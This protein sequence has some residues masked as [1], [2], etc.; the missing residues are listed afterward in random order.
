M[1]R[2]LWIVGI[3]CVAAFA[4]AQTPTVTIQKPVIAKSRL[5]KEVSLFNGKDFTGW[6]YCLA[7]PNTKF[8]S[9]WSIDPAEKAIVCVGNP[10]G[11]LRTTTDYGNFVLK[12][13]W[14]WTPGKEANSGC[15]IRMTG[16]DKVWPKSLE[17][18]LMTKTAGDF[19]LIDNFRLDTPPGYP[20][21]KSGIY[22][23]RLKTAE[24][25]L[26]E[27]NEYEIIADGPTVTLVINGEVVNQGVNVEQATGKILF[28]SEGGEIH[29]R[30]IRVWPLLK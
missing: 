30:N 2:L 9:V 12:F 7:D 25:P 29:F 18:Q 6:T 13:Q 24:K 26:G 11:Y 19:F 16:P 10:F 4:V 22:Q 8:E 28:Q 27:W 23:Q 3:A 1:N 20:N 17:A 5:G 14:R 15:L 21:A